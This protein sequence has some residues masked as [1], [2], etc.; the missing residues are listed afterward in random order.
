MPRTSRIS[1][2]VRQPASIRIGTSGPGRR[3][4][5]NQRVSAEKVLAG[6]L[7]SALDGVA[8]LRAIRNAAGRIVDFRWTRI[9]PEG[10]R[11]LGRK[12]DV[13][14]GRKLLTTFPDTAHSGL[15]D[16]WAAAVDSGKPLRHEQEYIHDGDAGL[17][18]IFRGRRR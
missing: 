5:S 3:L 12:A 9:N 17:D 1:S 6:V 10:E 15:M 11:I 18:R 16:C 8:L 4:T 2:G 14:I 7:N 13:L